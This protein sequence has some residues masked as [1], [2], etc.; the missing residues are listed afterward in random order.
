MRRIVSRLALA[1]ALGAAACCCPDRPPATLPDVV[2]V[3]ELQ[4][5]SDDIS[6]PMDAG[7]RAELLKFLGVHGNRDSM[8]E[9]APDP[10]VAPRYLPLL[11]LL[12]QPGLT[13]ESLGTE[14][15]KPWFANPATGQVVDARKPRLPVAGTVYAVSDGPYWW[16]FRSTGG[17]LTELV[18]FKAGPATK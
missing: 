4:I 5:R 13:P 16:V 7:A 3:R 6:L 10:A 8:G 14:P 17:R 9:D 12:G 18:V 11:D 15:F 2:A 1:V